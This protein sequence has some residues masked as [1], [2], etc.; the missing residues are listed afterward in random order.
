[1]ANDLLTTLPQVYQYLYHSATLEIDFAKRASSSGYQRK[2]CH[3]PC[4]KRRKYSTFSI[5]LEELFNVALQV[6]GLRGRQEPVTDLAASVHDELFKVPQDVRRSNR[7]VLERKVPGSL[8]GIQV[9][10]VATVVL[11]GLVHAQEPVKGLGLDP[12]HV[13]LFQQVKLGDEAVSGSRIFEDVI[14]FLAV[15]VLLVAK[16]VAGRAKNDESLIPV[17]VRDLVQLEVIPLR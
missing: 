4:E 8:R 2:T 7:G 13:G 17:L 15:A 10:L 1:M 16:L 11:N 5:L 3:D 12:N 14:D 9:R 6:V